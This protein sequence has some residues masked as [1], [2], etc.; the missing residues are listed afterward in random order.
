MNPVPFIIGA[1]AATLAGT[2]L[3]GILSYRAMRDAERK[4]EQ[5]RREP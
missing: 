3:L 1:Y 5:L 4:A 2:T